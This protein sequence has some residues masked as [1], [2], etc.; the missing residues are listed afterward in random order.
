VVV[1]LYRI[2]LDNDYLSLEPEDA[3]DAKSAFIQRKAEDISS[4][5]RRAP[6]SKVICTASHV[7]KFEERIADGF[8]RQPH[9]HVFWYSRDYRVGTTGLLANFFGSRKFPGKQNIQ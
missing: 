6:Y 4:V 5:I 3:Y 8:E 7:Y 9:I 2:S 1:W